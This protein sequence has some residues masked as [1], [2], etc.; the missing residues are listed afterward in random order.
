MSLVS[1]LSALPL[2]FAP[3]LALGACDSAD[4]V[5]VPAVVEKAAQQDPAQARD[6]ILKA[7]SSRV[8]ALNKGDVDGA[9]AVYAPEA[10]VVVPGQS[11]ITDPAAIRANYASLLGDD[12]LRMSITPG[13]IWVSAGA[14]FAVTTSQIKIM[15]PEADA[16]NGIDSTNQAVW[17]RQADGTWKIVS[18]YSVALPAVTSD[19][20][21]QTSPADTPDDDAPATKASAAS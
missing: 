9:V 18:E 14:D 20:N 17:Q 4:K 6:A 16:T 5:A 10:T 11:P 19:A 1:R 15:G 3:L 13:R 8:D 7:Q 12:K 2:I 21:A